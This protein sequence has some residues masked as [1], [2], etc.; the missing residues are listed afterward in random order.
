MTTTAKHLPLANLQQ[1]G[2][3]ALRVSPLTLGTNVSAGPS[4][5]MKRSPSLTATSPWVVTPLIPR[6]FNP[7]GA[8]T[9]SEEKLK[10]SL[11][12]G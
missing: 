8:T 3:S 10:R 11:E 5:K 1:V 7:S 6:T 2:S 9:T 12:T 4:T